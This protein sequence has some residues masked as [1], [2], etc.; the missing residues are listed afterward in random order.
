VPS[1][2][3]RAPDLLGQ[4]DYAEYYADRRQVEQWT[5]REWWKAK[6]GGDPDPEQAYR[7]R[8]RTAKRKTGDCHMPARKVM[9]HNPREPA[10]MSG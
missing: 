6:R 8:R 7:Q 3:C 1:F 10:W 5:L 4:A 2:G 9:P